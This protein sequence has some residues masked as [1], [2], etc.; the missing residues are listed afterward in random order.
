MSLK[1]GRHPVGRTWTELCARSSPLR[2]PIADI[3]RRLQRV[4]ERLTGISGSLRL[5]ISYNASAYVRSLTI[6]VRRSS[7]TPS[8]IL[9]HPRFR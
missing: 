8:S 9:I 2:W 7:P 6:T 5:R 4:D 1:V 3:R